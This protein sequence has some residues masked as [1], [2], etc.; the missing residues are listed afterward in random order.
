MVRR[1]LAKGNREIPEKGADMVEE[2]QGDPEDRGI[3]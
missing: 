2:N 1:S 3:L